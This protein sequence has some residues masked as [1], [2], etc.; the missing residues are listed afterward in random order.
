MVP[1]ELE[2]LLPFYEAM[3]MDDRQWFFFKSQEDLEVCVRFCKADPRCW[4]VWYTLDED[5]SKQTCSRAHLVAVLEAFRVPAWDFNSKLKESILTQAA[6]AHLYMEEVQS[7]LG[8]KEVENAVQ[9]AES[10][11][12][13]LSQSIVKVLKDTEPNPDPKETDLENPQRGPIAT[14]KPNLKIIKN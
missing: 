8:E 11:V 9:S 1:K 12:S 14:A 3:S 5:A 10:F 13:E 7:I 4:S 6:F 2:E